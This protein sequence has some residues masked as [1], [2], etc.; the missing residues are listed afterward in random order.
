MTKEPYNTII[1]VELMVPDILIASLVFS[2]VSHADDVLRIFKFPGLEVSTPSDLAM[3]DGL[4]NMLYSYA[5]S[6]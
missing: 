5:S 2:G 3:I 1:L 6:G 4:I